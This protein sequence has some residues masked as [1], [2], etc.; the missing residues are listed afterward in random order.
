MIHNLSRYGVCIAYALAL[1]GCTSL[2]PHGK[3]EAQTPWTTYAEAQAMFAK[4]VPNKTTL[5]DLKAIGVEPGRTPNVILLSHADLLRRLVATSSLD[6][7]LLDRS[8]QECIASDHN[9]YALEIAQTRQDK[10]RIGNFWLDILNF[11]RTTDIT[12][13]RFDAII[14][15]QNDVVVYKLWTGEPVIH[16]IEGEST[17]LGPFQGIG[18]SSVF[19]H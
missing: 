13:W 9:C 17:P 14:D 16:Q 11:Q 6:V 15:I 12:G 4:I 7:R 1:T 8:L 2:L 5:A 3:Q 19:Y 10:K 18:T